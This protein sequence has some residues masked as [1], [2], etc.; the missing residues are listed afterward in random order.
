VAAFSLAAA[1]SALIVTPSL[2]YM[3]EA[4]SEAGIGSFGVAYGIYNMAWG[5]GLLTGPALGGFFYE[6][7]G[8][9]ALAL[10]WSPGLLAVTLLLARV[11]SSGSSFP[12]IKEPVV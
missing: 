4:T 3:G 10:A 9:P 12:R 2:T 5:A 6:R 11:K 7:M 1:G 8:F